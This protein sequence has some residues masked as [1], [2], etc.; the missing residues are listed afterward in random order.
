LF[1]LF[2]I[3]GVVDAG[4]KFVTVVVDTGGMVSLMIQEKKPEAKIS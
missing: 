3:A 4:G 1:S 2:A